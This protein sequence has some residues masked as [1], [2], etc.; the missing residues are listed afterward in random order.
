MQRLQTVST[1]YSGFGPHVRGPHAAKCNK[2]QLFTCV[3][4]TGE[5]IVVLFLVK[6]GSPSPERLNETTIPDVFRRGPISQNVNQ[7]GFP[8]ME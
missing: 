3:V 1:A 8:D 6:L 7:T 5:E 2:E 4:Q